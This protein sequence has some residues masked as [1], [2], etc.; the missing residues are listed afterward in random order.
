VHR[1]ELV[2]PGEPGLPGVQ[3]FERRLLVRERLPGLPFDD[4]LQDLRTSAGEV[5][6]DLPVAGRGGLADVVDLHLIDA[7]L[8]QQR[9]RGVDDPC[10]GGCALR[11]PRLF[12]HEASFLTADDRPPILELLLHSTGRSLERTLQKSAEGETA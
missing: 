10:P 2:L 9:R 5:V 1:E 7:T 11:G 6:E 3:F 4:C 12:R 8:V